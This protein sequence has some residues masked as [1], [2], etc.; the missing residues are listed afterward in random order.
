MPRRPIKPKRRRSQTEE[1]TKAQLDNL[2]MKDFLGKLHPDE[3][4]IAKKFGLYCWDA[5]RKAGC[6]RDS[7][8]V[9]R[10]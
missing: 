2:K 5:W 7:G 3:I 1:L 4:P 9:V 8:L 6:P 10:N